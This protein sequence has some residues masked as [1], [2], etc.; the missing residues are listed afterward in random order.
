MTPGNGDPF[1][2]VGHLVRELVR[3]LAV[4]NLS[5]DDAAALAEAIE[6]LVT[7]FDA[8]EPRGARSRTPP[9]PADFRDV[10]AG[11]PVMG[12]RNPIAPPVDVE[13][14][15]KTVRGRANLPRQ[16]EGPPGHV[17]GAIIAGIFDMM[18]GVANIVSENPGMTGTLEI[19]YINPTPLNTD[20]VFEAKTTGTEG[21]KIFAVGTCHAGD[22]L[23]AEAKGIFVLPSIE[24]AKEYFGHTWGA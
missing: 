1:D 24:R 14:D 16:Y 8:M 6:P 7:K 2:H 11:D 9:N 20:L 22:R 23:T 15:G 3:H 10:F 18:L 17:H 5:A 21:R 12:R 19:R 13:I 4:T